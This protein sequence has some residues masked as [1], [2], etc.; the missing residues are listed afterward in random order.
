MTRD[1]E[2]IRKIVVEIQSR[3]EAQYG[4]VT[5]SPYD[6][7]VVARHLELMMDAGLIEAQKVLGSEMAYPFVVVKDLTW[8]GHDFASALANENVWGKI[9][10]T[11]SPSDLAAMPLGVI[12][13]VSV[14]LL[15]QWAKAQL[16]LS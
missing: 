5:L 12:K 14:A 16:G 13:D 6:E 1:M 7:A 4:P 3:K 9:K 8:S 2:L 11:F 15:A 10:K